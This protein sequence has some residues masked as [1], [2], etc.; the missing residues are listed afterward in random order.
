MREVDDQV[1]PARKGGR[2][3]KGQSGNPAG[4]PPGSTNA[5]PKGCVQAVLS[6]RHRTPKDLDPELVA[7][8]DEAFGVIVRAMRGEFHFQ[9][10]GPRIRAATT[11]REEL[12]GKVE[13]RHLVEGNVTFEVVSGLAGLP[14]GGDK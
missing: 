4:R 2:F 3:Q 1:K 9:D 10:A 13:E 11:V 7:V 12:C 14:K 8:A 6:L 5:L